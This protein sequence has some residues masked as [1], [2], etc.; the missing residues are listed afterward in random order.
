MSCLWQEL[1]YSVSA[2]LAI[3]DNNMSVTFNNNKGC[4][5]QMRVVASDYRKMIRMR[6]M[7]TIIAVQYK[8]TK[9]SQT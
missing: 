7:A 5:S 4:N 1:L 9:L 6:M 8:Y 2:T 3:S